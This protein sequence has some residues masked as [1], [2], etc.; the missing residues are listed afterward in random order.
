[1]EEKVRRE[2][3]RPARAASLL[4]GPAGSS[5]GCTSSAVPPPPQ[6]P[7]GNHVRS[8]GDA[9]HVAGRAPCSPG[10][11]A[12]H[13]PGLRACQRRAASS[14]WW[15]TSEDG[16][17]PWTAAAAVL[18]QV[19]EERGAHRPAERRSWSAARWPAAGR[20]LLWV[21]RGPQNARHD[22]PRPGAWA[23]A[24]VPPAACEA[25]WVWSTR[26]A[27]CLTRPRKSSRSCC[28]D[29][30]TLSCDAWS[31]FS[32]MA[33]SA[34]PASLAAPRVS[35]SSC[36]KC[37]LDFP[38]VDSQ[39]AVPSDED[40][41]RRENGANSTLRRVATITAMAA[42]SFGCRS[43]SSRRPLPAATSA[44]LVCWRN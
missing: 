4:A 7:G 1:M 27:K 41:L 19:A 35:P 24:R 38:P 15:R 2:S 13:T 25:R 31:F 21:A 30:R 14:C 11:P 32:S 8:C 3:Q 26:S 44:I 20:R 9:V 37:P 6:P 43:L 33:I 12:L 17:P 40:N 18:V 23:S 42:I 28:T 34:S 39:A 36:P 10:R 5:P 16:L 22:A 29:L